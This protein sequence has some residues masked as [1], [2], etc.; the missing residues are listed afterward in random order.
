[1]NSI[2]NR[3]LPVFVQICDYIRNGIFSGELP[4]DSQ[5]PS[6]RQLALELA[7]NPNTVQKALL[8]L[9]QDG[10]LYTKGTVGRFVTPDRDLI[11]R[12]KQKTKADA[13]RE[14]LQEAYARGVTRQ[15]LLEYLQKEEEAK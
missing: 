11:A 8:L 15:E 7:T 4:P 5:I 6:V 9:E 10:L 14:V 12:E 1:M 13:L 2:I 3:N